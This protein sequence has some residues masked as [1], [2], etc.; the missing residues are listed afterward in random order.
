MGHVKAGKKK[1][2]TI[3]DVAQDAG[4]SISTVSLAL[5]SP[6]RV[7]AATLQR[8]M[9][10]VDRLGFAPKA[11]AVI[12]ARHG[13][14]RVGVIAPFTS[15]PAETALRLNG[16]LG[17][18]Q[19]DGREVVVFDQAS[20]ATSRLMSL[21]V[22]RKVDGLIIISIPFE[23][24]IA[25][26]LADNGTPTVVVDI[27]HPGMNSVVIDHRGGGALVG[28]FLGERGHRRIAY[29]GHRQE[30]DYPSQS[31]EKLAG[32]RDACETAPEVVNVDNSRDDA[33]RA[34]LELLDRPDRPTAVFAHNDLLASGILHAAHRL[35]LRVPDDLAI[36]GFNDTDIAEAIGLTTVRQPFERSGEL[37]MGML[38]DTTK[39]SSDGTDGD[40]RTVTLGVTIVER[41]TA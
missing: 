29:I 19:S 3:Y 6:E 23:D 9:S 22:T 33:I 41:D 32:L 38:L 20:G 18:A 15:F 40:S 4:V 17:R 39:N 34:G 37:A 2:A 35:G 12:R 27:P 30:Y 31:L 28:A 36:V 8:I 1:G 16:I 26:R 14:G 7:Q 21:P 13:T 24:D 11:E 5:N 10:A 25:Q